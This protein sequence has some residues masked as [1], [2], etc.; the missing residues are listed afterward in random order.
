MISYRPFLSFHEFDDLVV[1][2]GASM[3]VCKY[4][5]IYKYESMPVKVCIYASVQIC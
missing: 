1:S 5:S 3:L 2:K 4:V